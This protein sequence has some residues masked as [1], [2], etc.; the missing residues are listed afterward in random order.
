MLREITSYMISCQICCPVSY[1][2][3]LPRAGS[4]VHAASCFSLD[5]CLPQEISVAA[6]FDVKQNANSSVQPV[7]SQMSKINHVAQSV[8]PL[9]HILSVCITTS[10]PLYCVTTTAASS[11]S[12]LFRLIDNHQ[13]MHR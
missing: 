4:A 11:Q 13:L 5:V 3:S 8:V 9:S 2:P 1:L 6:W 10:V 12:T 7:R